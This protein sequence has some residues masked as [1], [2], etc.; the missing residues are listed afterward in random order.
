MRASVNVEFTDDELVR[1]AED[2]GRRLL[3]GALRG[4]R[5]DPSAVRR[6]L[7]ALSHGV[8][9]G[10]SMRDSSPY[11]PPAPD[12]GDSFYR[13]AP[14]GGPR[15]TSR[16]GVCAP[17][18]ANT[19]QEEG[20]MCHVCGTYNIKHREVCRQCDHERCFEDHEDDEGSGTDEPNV[21][22]GSA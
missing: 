5:L 21:P 12:D 16:P 11:P 15:P 17:V 1:F 2:V 10:V 13:T 6:L 20:W 7:E 22:S 4:V 18:D 8:S 14:P 3:F 9:V 19:Y